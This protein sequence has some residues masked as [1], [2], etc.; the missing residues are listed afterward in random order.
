MTRRDVLEQ[1]EREAAAQRAAREAQEA[2]DRVLMPPPVP[3]VTRRDILVEEERPVPK[4]PPV[5]PTRPQRTLETIARRLS[6]ARATG[7]RAEAERLEDEFYRKLATDYARAP[8]PSNAQEKYEMLRDVMKFFQARDWT[9]L[10]EYAA[11]RPEYDRIFEL[12]SFEF[13]DPAQQSA[14]D[15]GLDDS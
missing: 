3:F 6:Q 10:P 5:V 11:L 2:R 14:A 1:E 15:L 13:D 4:Q 12:V 8:M 9:N 7:Q